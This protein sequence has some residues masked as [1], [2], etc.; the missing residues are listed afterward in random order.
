[1]GTSIAFRGR[2]RRTSLAK[3]VCGRYQ[4]NPWRSSGNSSPIRLLR[5]RKPCSRNPVA[6]RIAAC[7]LRVSDSVSNAT[8]YVTGSE[9]C[10]ESRSSCGDTDVVRVTFAGRGCNRSR[11]DGGGVGGARHFSTGN[12]G[13]G[14]AA[15]FGVG[16]CRDVR[17][18]AAYLA[19]LGLG[20]GDSATD[21]YRTFAALAG[22]G[23]ASLGRRRMSA[24]RRLGAATRIPGH[25]LEPL[26]N[27]R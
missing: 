15:G 19:D 7:F 20:G 10:A 18:D 6:T 23:T 2:V 27:Q 17:Q 8:A 26:R 4:R 13:I 16:G 22:C 24:A 5:V 14:T 11:C 12:C 21:A 9:S 3:P 25:C 1:M